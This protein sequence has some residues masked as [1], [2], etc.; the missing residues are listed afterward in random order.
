MLRQLR[1]IGLG[2]TPATRAYLAEAFK[3]ALNDPNNIA[4]IQESGR[5]VKEFL[6]SGPKGFVKVES[7]WE[8]T[9]LITMTIFGGN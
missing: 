5:I 8:G 9:K 4:K 3:K 6:L 2:D 7:V 1:S